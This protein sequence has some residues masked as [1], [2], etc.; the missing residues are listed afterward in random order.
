MTIC[1]LAHPGQAVAEL[2]I[3]DKVHSIRR[4]NTRV[5]QSAILSALLG[6]SASLALAAPQHSTHNSKHFASSI[7]VPSI[8]TQPASRTVTAGQTATFSVAA[9]GTA[10]LNYQWRKNGTAIRGAT[11]STYTTPATTASSNS[12]QFIV[13]VSNSAGKA[14]SAAAILTVNAASSLLNTSSTSLAFDNVNVSSSNTQ[15]VTLTNAGNSSVTISNVVVAGAGFNVSGAAVGLILS[16][17]QTANLSATF[18]P[19]AAGNATGSITVMGNAANS[20]MVITLSGAGVTQASHSV[21]L[22]WLASTSS[23]TGYNVYSST[24]SG[25]PYAKLTSPPVASTSYTDNSVQQGQTYYYVVTAV[26][27]N[28]ESAYSVQVPAVV[29]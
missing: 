2:P 8:T 1:K 27:Q 12:E 23:V 19:A 21:S 20:P 29:P 18:D 24:V 17:G 16:S 25:G 28:E 26:S 7:T 14:T 11:S 3:E 6:F 9:T 10:P 5:R 4:I 22:S 15:N 13:V